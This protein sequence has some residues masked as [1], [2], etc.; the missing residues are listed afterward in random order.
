MSIVEMT[1]SSEAAVMPSRLISGPAEMEN[2]PLEENHMVPKNWAV[3]LMI[4]Q[5]LP[6]WR[7]SQVG[8]AWETMRPCLLG[9]PHGNR[10]SLF[11]SQD[12]AIAMKKIFVAV[13]ESG[14]YGPVT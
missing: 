4:E 2:G 13:V 8:E 7:W 9:Q 12:T 5:E 6:N 10:S 14:M 11:V 1:W 3:P